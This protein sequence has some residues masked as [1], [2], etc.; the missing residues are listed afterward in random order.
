MEVEEPRAE[1]S[2]PAVVTAAAAPW[3][4]PMK[5]ALI[6]SEQLAV[7]FGL[8]CDRGEG[9][10]S[11]WGFKISSRYMLGSKQPKRL[12]VNVIRSMVL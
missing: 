7:C 4:Q 5:T 12:K 8:C 3:K 10:Y 11:F 9:N 1:P 2:C 6:G